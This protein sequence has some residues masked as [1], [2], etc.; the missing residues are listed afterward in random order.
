MVD[1]EIAVQRHRDHLNLDKAKNRNYWLLLVNHYQEIGDTTEAGKVLL[2]WKTR[3]PEEIMI[4]R[5]NH[6]YFKEK[7]LD[8]TIRLLHEIIDKNPRYSDA[9]D[10]LGVCNLSLGRYDSA[11]A[12][13]RIADGLNPHRASTLSN[14]GRAYQFSGRF[15]EAEE[16]F[17]R[18]ISLDSSHFAIYYNLASLSRQTYDTAQYLRFLQRAINQKGAPPEFEQELVVAYLA[19]GK[20]RKAAEVIARSQSLLSDTLFAKGIRLHYPEV[21]SLFNDKTRR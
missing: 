10:F 1:P 5:A 13:L 14:L 3:F 11:L 18:A 9:Y 17:L 7:K 6:L 15:K 12:L 19:L 8:A 2:E 16:V 20:V 21:D 4:E